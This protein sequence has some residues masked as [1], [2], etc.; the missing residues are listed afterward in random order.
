MALISL[1]FTRISELEQAAFRS[2]SVKRGL[3]GGSSWVRVVSRVFMVRGVWK[4]RLKF[5]FP[6]MWRSAPMNFMVS[7]IFIIEYGGCISLML[8]FLQRN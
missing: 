6:V 4:L 2:K 8:C 7:C 1:P 5:V 3:R